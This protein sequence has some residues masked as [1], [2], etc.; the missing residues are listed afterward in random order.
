MSV[1]KQSCWIIGVDYIYSESKDYS[2]F[3][4]TFDS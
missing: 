4:A 2:F 3:D 1:C